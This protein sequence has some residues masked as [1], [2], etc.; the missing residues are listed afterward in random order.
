MTSQQ[1]ISD[2]HLKFILRRF[3]QNNSQSTSTCFTV[4]FFR[5]QLCKCHGD[6]LPTSTS[7]VKSAFLPRGCLALQHETGKE[8][9]SCIA[10]VQSPHSVYSFAHCFQLVLSTSSYC[11]LVWMRD[12][13]VSYIPHG[14]LC[15]AC[16]VPRNLLVQWW[17]TLDMSFTSAA[18]HSSERL[19]ATCMFL[20]F[21]GRPK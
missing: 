7:L 1:T 11:L 17:G 4:K 12:T 8:C 6:A 19:L 2:K 5:L 13:L 18:M 15:P 21:S 10:F 14:R 20:G 16:T 3:W 9:F